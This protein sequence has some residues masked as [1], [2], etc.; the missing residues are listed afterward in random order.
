[1]ISPHFPPDT[2]AGTHRV[3]LLAPHLAGFGWEPTV[4]TVEPDAYEG[5]LDPDLAQ[6]VPPSLRVVRAPAWSAQATRRVGLGDLGLRAL[7]G[8]RRAAERLLARERFDA[9][10]ITIYPTYPALLGPPLKRR[11]GIPFVLD[12]Q[13]PWVGAWGL[14][15]GGGPGGLPDLKSRLTR[16]LAVRLEPRVV[17]R[18][19]ALTAVSART[20]EDV[21]A[22]VPDAQPDLCAAIPLGF[23]EADL[24]ALRRAHE[25]HADYL[26]DVRAEEHVDFCDLSPELSRELRGLRLWLP[27]RLY[28]AEAFREQLREKLA[29]AR[30]IHDA[31]RADARFALED[32]PQLS[33]VAFRLRDDAATAALLD[34]VHA[35]RRVFLSS[36]TMRG[37]LTLRACVLS[38]RTHADRVDEAIAALREEARALVPTG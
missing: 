32:E 23:D 31:L 29:L 11:H 38:F 37:R 6:L 21:L 15:V 26:R 1:M 14:D 28:G 5:L 25:S 4:V 17:R 9:L 8:L 20:Y 24:D 35:R 30:R 33:V 13:D 18:A 16:A 36:T 19:D 10:F 2:S 7:P 12:Y 34:R 3:R 22:R 27:L